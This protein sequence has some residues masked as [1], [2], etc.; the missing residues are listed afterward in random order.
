MIDKELLLESRFCPCCQ[1][2]MR[3]VNVHS[4]VKD[5]LQFKCSRLQCRDVKVGIR[6]GTIFDSNHLTLME[7]V[8]VVFYYFSRGFNA[9]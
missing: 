5:G 2:L 6:E 1:K 7:T 3:I 8:R 9:L 4:K